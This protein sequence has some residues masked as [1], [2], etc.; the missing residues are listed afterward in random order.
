MRWALE[1][2]GELAGSSSSSHSPP[3]CSTRTFKM[4]SYVT[5]FAPNFLFVR[6]PLYLVAERVVALRHQPTVPPSSLLCVP[7]D[8]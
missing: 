6:R 1:E 7:P 3:G 4:T 8:G 5:D 2:R